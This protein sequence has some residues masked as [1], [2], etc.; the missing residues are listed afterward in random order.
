MRRSFGRFGSD[1]FVVS[2]A[3]FVDRD[4]GIELRGDEAGS[5]VGPQSI[6][7]RRIRH[8]QRLEGR[9]GFRVSPN[10][11]RDLEERELCGCDGEEQQR[12]AGTHHAAAWA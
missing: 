8:E 10:P 9:R 3:L 11:Q 4:L 1:G 6:A 12:A 2:D 7:D 5:R